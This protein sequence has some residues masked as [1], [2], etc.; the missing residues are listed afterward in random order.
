MLGLNSGLVYPMSFH[1]Y[2][3]AQKFIWVLPLHLMEKRKQT[4]RQTQYNDR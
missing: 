3:V 4:Y 1:K 2:W